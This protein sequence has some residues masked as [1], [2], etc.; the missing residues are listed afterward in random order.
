MEEEITAGAGQDGEDLSEIASQALV[1]YL[2]GRINTVS[3]RIC[4]PG[5]CLSV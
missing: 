4:E 5:A 1:T 3:E 2:M